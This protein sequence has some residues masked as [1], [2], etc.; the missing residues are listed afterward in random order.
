MTQT[1]MFV[2]FK[3]KDLLKGIST[4]TNGIYTDIFH[5]NLRIGYI[6]GGG[7]KLF[8]AAQ[9]YSCRETTDNI[10]QAQQIALLSQE[11]QEKIRR[12]DRA[13]EKINELTVFLK[14]GGIDLGN[15]ADSDLDSRIIM[16]HDHLKRKFNKN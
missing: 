12:H 10:I 2:T 3:E 13:L 7:D 11:A 1:K 4:R 5:N 8:D 15:W 14:E 6:V 16:I 9:G